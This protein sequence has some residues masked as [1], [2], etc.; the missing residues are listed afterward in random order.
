MQQEEVVAE[1][2][3]VEAIDMSLPR[4]QRAAVQYPQRGALFDLNKQ[5]KQYSRNELAHP[6]EKEEREYH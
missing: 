1:S 3:G 2:S 4:K 5:G 6:C